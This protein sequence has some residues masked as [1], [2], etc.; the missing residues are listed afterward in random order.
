M[1]MNRS[2]SEASSVRVGASARIDMVW[3]IVRGQSVLGDAK[4][5]HCA[6]GFCGRANLGIEP[7]LEVCQQ[8]GLFAQLR[9]TSGSQMFRQALCEE[10]LPA[11]PVAEQG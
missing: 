4:V 2:P 1:P 11:Y 7:A 6:I 3:L 8:A 10:T 9:V 5:G